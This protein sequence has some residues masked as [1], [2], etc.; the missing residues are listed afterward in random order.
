MFEQ[1]VHHD[2]DVWVRRDLKGR[3]REHCLCFSC[4]RFVP[5]D[6]EQNCPLANLLYSLD[7]VT[8]LTTPVFEC[9]EFV[10]EESN[11]QS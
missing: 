3:H 8:G 5:E 10:E 7:V 2:W 11:G 6:R 1:Y 4:E 9:P